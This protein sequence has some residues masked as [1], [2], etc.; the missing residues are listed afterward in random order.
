MAAVSIPQQFLTFN[1]DD[2]NSLPFIDLN[3]NLTIGLVD[4]Y[5]FLNSFNIQ[6]IYGTSLMPDPG[7]PDHIK[8]MYTIYRYVM[9]RLYC[10]FQNNALRGDAKPIVLPEDIIFVNSTG[11]I[12]IPRVDFFKYIN[13]Y[14]I[15][16]INLDR[17][18]KPGEVISRRNTNPPGF[19][20]T[21]LNFVKTPMFKP[22]TRPILGNIT[23]NFQNEN[24]VLDSTSYV[25]ACFQRDHIDVHEDYIYNFINLISNVTYKDTANKDIFAFGIGYI[26]SPVNTGCA[27]NV[28]AF[29]GIFTLA[30]ILYILREHSS[31]FTNNNGTNESMLLNTYS[32]LNTCNIDAISG[33]PASATFA[34]TNNMYLYKFT[35]N[36]LSETQRARSIGG[37][38]KTS[39]PIIFKPYSPADPRLQLN[40]MFLQPV[41]DEIKKLA[42]QTVQMQIQLWGTRRVFTSIIKVLGRF[43]P[44]YNQAQNGGIPEYKHLWGHCYGIYIHII[45]KNSPVLSNLLS[46]YGIIALSDPNIIDVPPS[47]YCFLIS[48]AEPYFSRGLISYDSAF[49]HPNKFKVPYLQLNKSYINNFLTNISISNSSDCNSLYLPIK[50]LDMLTLRTL[51]DLQY[52]SDCR[53]YTSIEFQFV[54]NKPQHKSG[55]IAVVPYDD[56]VKVHNSCGGNSN[57]VIS[58][59]MSTPEQHAI[60]MDHLWRVMKN[61]VTQLGV[62]NAIKSNIPVLK[63]DNGTI[64]SSIEISSVDIIQQFPATPEELITNVESSTKQVIDIETQW[65]PKEIGGDLFNP[66]TIS[67]LDI[68]MNMIGSFNKTFVETITQTRETFADICLFIKTASDVATYTLLPEELLSNIPGENFYPET[69]RGGSKHK[70]MK[71]DEKYKIMKGDEKYK[72]MK[73]GAIYDEGLY[74]DSYVNTIT[75][76][77]SDNSEFS[78]KLNILQYLTTIDQTKLPSLNEILKDYN[79]QLYA[80]Y[81]MSKYN[82]IT[83]KLIAYVNNFI[84]M[85]LY[86]RLFIIDQIISYNRLNNLYQYFEDEEEYANALLNELLKLNIS[87]LQDRLFHEI[88]IFN[89][90]ELD[91]LQTIPPE[92]QGIIFS[93]LDLTIQER[94]F[95]TLHPTIQ[96]IIFP[97][98]DLTIQERIQ[99]AM[100]QHAIHEEEEEEEEEDEEEHAMQ[101]HAMQQH[102]MQQHAMQQHAMQQH[103]IHQRKSERTRTPNSQYEDHLIGKAYDEAMKWRVGGKTRRKH[104]TKRKTIKRKKIR[105]TIKRKLH[106]KRRRTH[107]G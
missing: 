8:T 40:P 5:I 91:K 104:N 6:Q 100:Q 33:N 14:F 1:L 17:M 52:Y 107:K 73:G 94:I 57:L 50:L 68:V 87:V 78:G 70:I 10:L 105:K 95:P 15:L 9:I 97:T 48:I 71:G 19:Y 67:A 89:Q 88:R 85:N 51:L 21:L 60:R 44:K 62:I 25:F 79:L 13:D 24:V 16:P 32:L 36:T 99:Y 75:D 23:K 58:S 101:Q 7:N 81:T 26:L 93:A 82:K 42:L 103:A 84:D 61:G 41:I 65:L 69:S 30:M 90:Y 28:C 106:K 35:I 72:I 102:A 29:I 18:G 34:N 96:G 83:P 63:S 86:N 98:L 77:L 11:D 38:G 43:L 20:S 2:T 56:L 53:C 31:F 59:T 4:K 45:N 55:T 64:P 27:V 22:Y 80:R 3:P 12:R 37:D 47:E 54:L 46:K 76:I 39:N 66:T 92:I 49:I 74:D